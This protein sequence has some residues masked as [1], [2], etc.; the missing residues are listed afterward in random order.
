MS[1]RI[2]VWVL[3]AALS[4]VMTSSGMVANRMITQLDSLS[5]RMSMTELQ[6]AALLETKLEMERR[7]I[8]IEDKLDVV[9][10]KQ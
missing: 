2:L 7:L 6:N 8:R 3:S 1:D 9:R 4:L 5:V 10:S